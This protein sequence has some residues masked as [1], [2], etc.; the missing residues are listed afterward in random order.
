VDD[1]SKLER[2]PLLTKGKIKDGVEEERD[3]QRVSTKG[4]GKK[5]KKRNT[6]LLLSWHFLFG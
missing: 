4:R 5:K 1:S 2:D 3:R 6:F